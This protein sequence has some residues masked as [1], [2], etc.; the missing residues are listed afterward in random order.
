M[1]SIAN[2]RLAGLRAPDDRVAARHRELPAAVRRRPDLGLKADVRP[3]ALERDGVEREGPARLVPKPVGA[4]RRDIDRRHVLVVD[5]D[6]AGVGRELRLEA[7]EA[8]LG[9]ERRG[10]AGELEVRRRRSVREPGEQHEIGERDIRDGDAAAAMTRAALEIAVQ[11]PAPARSLE[12]EIEAAPARGGALEAARDLAESRPLAPARIDEDEARIR[13]PRPVEGT[14]DAARLENEVEQRPERERDD[15][16][17]IRRAARALVRGAAG[18]RRG[19]RLR[20]AALGGDE[21]QA[22]VAVEGGADL[23][24]AELDRAR[25]QRA[26]QERLRIDADDGGGRAQHEV[27]VGVADLQPRGPKRDGPL[28]ERER[29]VLQ[30][31]VP[32]G[33]DP[34]GDRIG[35]PLR[36]ALEGERRGAQAQIEKPGGEPERR[37]KSE[38]DIERAAEDAAEPRPPAFPPDAAQNG[39]REKLH[40]GAD[41]SRTQGHHSPTAW[42]KSYPSAA[43]PRDR[44]SH[45]PPMASKYMKIRRKEGSMP[46]QPGDPAPDF[47]LSATAGETVSLGALKGR[48]VVLYFYPKDDTSGCTLEAQSFNALRSAFADAG[49]EVIGVSPD[50]LKSHDKFR[51]KYGLDLTLASDE[52]KDMLQAYGVWAEKSMY[53]RKYMGVER[54]T[55]L[56][57]R[58]GRVAQVWSKV[59]V[60]GHAEEVLEAARAL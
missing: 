35:D 28:L 13:H 15:G 18:R 39:A 21:G 29:R 37:R 17:A 33:A 54:T 11:L 40:S 8:P 9:N 50:S 12:A 56:I 46:L 27:A 45:A 23:E 16:R 58:A 57:D 20:L 42:R 53:G 51:A 3:G 41:R 48:K 5:L 59:K 2:A 7:G 30:H 10:V 49:T 32:A 43:K 25:L 14:D 26:G 4:R 31:D 47:T 60:P 22:A 36:Q 6:H 44:V 55:V 1:V 34:R 52:A 24:I 19:H 38:L